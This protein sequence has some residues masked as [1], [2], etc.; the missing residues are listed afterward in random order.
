M[1]LNKGFHKNMT[2]K[3][4]FGEPYET[5]LIKL[6]IISPKYLLTHY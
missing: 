6:D 4:V 2:G 5:K 1:E 3:P